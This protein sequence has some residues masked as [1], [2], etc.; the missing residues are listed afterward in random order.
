MAHR[1]YGS[2]EHRGLRKDAKRDR[3]Y[4]ITYNGIIT[5]TDGVDFSIEKVETLLEAL[6]MFLSFVRGNYCSLALVEGKTKMR[7][8]HGS[9]G[10]H[11]T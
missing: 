1:D 5:R 6:R 9:D 10:E 8:H 7:N 2:S 4:G 11:I 3:G